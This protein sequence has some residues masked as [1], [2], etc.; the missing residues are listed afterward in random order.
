MRLKCC[1]VSFCDAYVP[2][3]WQNANCLRRNCGEESFV[4][5]GGC[6]DVVG[7][8]TETG[9]QRLPESKLWFSASEL[10]AK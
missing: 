2:M 5:A 7:W 4:E 9:Q 8:A 10:D 1:L 6:D 3:R